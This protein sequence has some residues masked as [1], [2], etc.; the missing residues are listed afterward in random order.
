M[1]KK[2]CIFLM[3]ILAGCSGNQQP[4]ATEQAM[5][6]QETW[7]EMDDF[8]FVM[9][10]S[11]HPYKDSANLAPAK[12]HATEMA[13]R[14]AEWAE[15]PLPEKVN[16]P[17]VKELLTR[18]KED[19]RKF[20]Q[21]VTTAPDDSLGHALNVLHDNFHQLQEAWYAHAAGHEMH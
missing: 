16:N 3:I 19:T 13:T 8:H 1:I 14:A 12:Q 2:Y 6:D 17:E 7:K 5:P 21:M 18:L 15:S 20:S 4:S 9:A 10:E 11:F